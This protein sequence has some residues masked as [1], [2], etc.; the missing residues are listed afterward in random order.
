MCAAQRSQGL[1]VRCSSS[2]GFP[3]LC[4]VYLLPSREFQA[5]VAVPPPLGSSSRTSSQALSLRILWGHRK[6]GVSWETRRERRG[7]SPG[8]LRGWALHTGLSR[9]R[10][11]SFPRT[12]R[13]PCH[14]PA[15]ASRPVSVTQGG[16]WPAPR[17]C[18]H[19]A[20]LPTSHTPRSWPVGSRSSPQPA[21][22]AC[23]PASTTWHIQ[24]GHSGG[25]S[26]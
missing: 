6:L 3:F 1:A 11:S 20:P 23:A 10:A 8:A 9:S 18:Q 13:A 17:S 26:R 4:G 7:S 24:N 16:A 5:G 22:A 15:S 19:T 2:P 14:C 12:S 25:S 21:L